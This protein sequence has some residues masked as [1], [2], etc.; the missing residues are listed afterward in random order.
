MKILILVKLLLFTLSFNAA[1]QDWR[2]DV[3]ITAPR[4][5]IYELNSSEF[6]KTIMDG[7]RVALFYPV[8]VSDLLIP[9]QPLNHFF[10]K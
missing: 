10:E 3:E 5:N 1:A 2:R 8:T 6:Q 4:E 7:R 9:Y